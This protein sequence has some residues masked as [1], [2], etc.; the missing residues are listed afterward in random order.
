M[1]ENYRGFKIHR[2]GDGAY[3]WTHGGYCDAVEDIYAEIN[4]WIAEDEERDP[5]CFE[6]CDDAPSPA[7]WWREA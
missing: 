5:G 2:N 7:P 1:V 4:D 6:G 3:W